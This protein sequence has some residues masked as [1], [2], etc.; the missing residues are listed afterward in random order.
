MMP[1]LHNYITVDTEAFLSVE[2][3]LLAIY[4]MAKEVLSKDCGEDPESHAAKLLEIV[5]LQCKNKIDQAA[6][7]LVELAASRLLRKV[8]TSELRTMCL[9]VLIAALYYDPKLLFSVMEK[10]PDF[11]NHFIKQWLHDAD[12]F[13]GV[14]DRKLCVLGL[15]T[16]ITMPTKPAALIEMAPK[17]VPSLILLFEGL[18]RAYAAK[19][20]EAAEEEETDESDGGDDLGAAGDL[21][22]SDEDEIDDQGQ[23]YL[24]ALSRRAVNQTQNSAMPVSA[25]FNDI[26]AD[27]SDDS[28]SEYDPSEETVLE[29][30]TTPLDD[31]DCDVDEYLAF[32][33]V[34]QHIQ[35]SEPEWY[36]ALTSNLNEAQVKSLGEIV[37][38]ADQ[39]AAAKESKRIQQQGG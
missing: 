20:L 14:H 21:L 7:M 6:P 39:R 1:A 31:E 16:L 11:T 32:K 33:H 34:M 17:V 28:D 24:E 35:T 22:S 9:Q 18:K 19:A 12:C 3:R 2:Q 25:A 26:D 23:D 10:M 4:N 27:A 36:K 29:A 30:Y 37:V 5:L 8:N 13:L 15:C 38:L